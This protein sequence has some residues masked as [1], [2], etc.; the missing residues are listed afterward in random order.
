[1][2]CSL[3]KCFHPVV[4]ACLQDRVDV[5]K[6]NEFIAS[7]RNFDG[8]FGA[9]PGDESHAGQIFTAVGALAIGGGLHHVDHDLLGWW[10]CERQVKSGGLNGASRLPVCLPGMSWKKTNTDSET[11]CALMQDD[12]RSCLTSVTRGGCYQVYQ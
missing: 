7:C 10:L 8:G 12:Q 9:T 4:V 6:G 11:C 5:T 2:F 1:M 3:G